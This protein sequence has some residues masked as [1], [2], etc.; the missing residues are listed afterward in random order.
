MSL[1]LP[2]SHSVRR[3]LL[4][5]A[6]ADASHGSG[7]GM[8]RRETLRAVNP[9]TTANSP[10][11]TPPSD[12]FSPSQVR[13]ALVLCVLLLALAYALAWFFRAVASL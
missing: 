5:R 3:V 8:L 1:A 13:R 12:P 7:G 6:I 4:A 9:P 2:P 11:E 10:S